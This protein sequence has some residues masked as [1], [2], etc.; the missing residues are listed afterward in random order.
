MLAELPRALPKVKSF[1]ELYDQ[2]IYLKSISNKKWEKLAN[3][4][5]VKTINLSIRQKRNISL[6][7][8]IKILTKNKVK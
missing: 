8:E 1:N 6:I 3:K 7:D 4:V 2:I 5:L